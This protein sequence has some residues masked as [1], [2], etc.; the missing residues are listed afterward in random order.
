[1]ALTSIIAQKT[2]KNLMTQEGGKEFL[3]NAPMEFTMYFPLFFDLFNG[4]Q[5]IQKL[6]NNE[7]GNELV[8]FAAD[9]VRDRLNGK[10]KMEIE[11]DPEK[12]K[13]LEPIFEEKAEAKPSKGKQ[14]VK[15]KAAAAVSK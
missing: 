12:Y 5:T 11:M 7:T 8:G 14:P 13:D 2:M 4:N 9:A 6:E 3:E 10:Y 1:M 15:V